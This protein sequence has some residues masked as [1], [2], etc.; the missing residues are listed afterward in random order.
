MPAMRRVVVS[1]L[2]LALPVVAAAPKKTSAKR[3]PAA[4]TAAHVSPE[5]IPHSIALFL[6][7]LSNDGAKPV[8]FKARAVGIRFFFEEG[9]SVTVYRYA[10]GTYVRED[11]VRGATLEAAILSY[12]AMSKHTK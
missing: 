10:N 12:G 3:K 4:V 8:T 2:C 9:G 11:V 7:T 5:A 6:R 1:L